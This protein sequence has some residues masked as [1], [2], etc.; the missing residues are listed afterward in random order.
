MSNSDEYV[1]DNIESMQRNE[2][3]EG[4]TGTELGLP[5]GIT[6]TVLAASDANPRWRMR[7]EEIAAELRRL[8]N[9]RATPQ[10][11]RE[12][13]C[14]IYAECLVIGW[15]G[16]KSKGIEIPFSVEACRAFLMAAFDAYN[17]VD[18]MVY[19]T[20]NFRGQ[21]VTAIVDAAKN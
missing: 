11:Q 7:S 3:I 9:A 8:A 5:G 6:L 20:K 17:A 12:Y 19:E 14:K 18:A 15:R 4:K 10:R 1:F 2:E 16:V 13:L 21:R